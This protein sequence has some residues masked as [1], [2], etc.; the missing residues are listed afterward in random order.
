MTRGGAVAKRA[1]D[2]VLAS[3]LLVLLA[4][5]LLVVCVLVMLDS[6]GPPLFVQRRV[7]AGGRVFRM[8]KFRSMRKDAEAHSGP[9]FAVPGDP[10][11]TRLGQL[12]RRTNIDELPQLVNVV[13]GHLSLV[14]PRPERPEFVTL[15]ER[16]IPGYADRHAVRPGITGL[17]QVRGL[18]GAHTSLL[19]RLEL[20][21]QYIERWSLALDLRILARTAFD[22]LRLALP[23]VA[24]SPSEG[25]DHYRRLALTEARPEV[26]KR[27][28]EPVRRLGPKGVL[29]ENE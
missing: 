15:F 3:A 21:L 13:A 2:L 23:L 20:D 9:V 11:C 8:L 28:V 29:V 7:G 17:A 10:R 6:A 24:A 12:L 18:R 22:C 26:E 27:T 19:T 16:T 1:I 5:L 25:Q 14:G 4:P